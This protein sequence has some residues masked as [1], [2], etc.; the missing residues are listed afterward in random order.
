MT[1]N[2][3][4]LANQR[5][6]TNMSWIEFVS[7]TGAFLKGVGW[8]FLPFLALPVL[9][10]I[11]PNNKL[12][13][14]LSDHLVLIIDGFNNSIGEWMKWALPLLVLTVAFGI[15]ADSIFG[16]SWTKLDE[17]AKYLHAGSIM[18][19]AAAALLA[20][21][22]VRVDI[23]HTRM[24]PHQKARIDLW[25]FFIF[26]MPVCLVLFWSAQG[27]TRGAW[28]N[29][30]GSAEADGIR[31]V[32]LLKSLIPAF[33]LMMLLQGLAIALRAVSVL[34]GNTLPKRPPLIDPLFHKSEVKHEP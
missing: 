32:F 24:N 5:L 14:S 12:I 9:R 13:A 25:A 1:G 29:F 10:L 28:S 34:T 8:V 22:H 3:F 17:S 33:C 4:A 6:A 21:Q 20:G 15:F 26:L 30:E 27:N 11:M 18:L 19:G 23:F 31:G 7:Q 2:I 16:L